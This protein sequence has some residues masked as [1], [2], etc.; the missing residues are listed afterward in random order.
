MEGKEAP[1]FGLVHAFTP[2]PN[3]AHHDPPPQRLGGTFAEAGCVW[4]GCV[5]VW[6][7][8]GWVRVCVIALCEVSCLSL[9]ASRPL[10]APALLYS[11]RTH[12]HT[13]TTP[14]THNHRKAGAAAGR[15]ATW[16]GEGDGRGPKLQRK[17]PQR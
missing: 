5:W 13:H 16:P 10:R 14:T 3:R 6:V 8:V 7:W 15:R 9:E 4:S 17:Q 1:L 2:K 12:R 11:S